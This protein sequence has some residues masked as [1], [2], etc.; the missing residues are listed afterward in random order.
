[1]QAPTARADE[2]ARPAGD[3]REITFRRHA[4]AEARARAILPAGRN[5]H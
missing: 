5:F 2:V 3:P 1:M 4:M